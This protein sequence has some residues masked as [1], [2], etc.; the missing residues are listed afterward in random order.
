MKS[1]V[2]R[3]VATVPPLICSVFLGW[4]ALREQGYR[5]ALLG[6]GALVT[7]LVAVL[8]GRWAHREWAYQQRLQRRLR[9]IEQMGSLTEAQE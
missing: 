1:V 3:V 2:W 8:A 5:G 7:L 6:A 4:G 9:G